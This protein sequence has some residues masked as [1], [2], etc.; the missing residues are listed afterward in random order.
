M[1]SLANRCFKIMLPLFF[2]IS[3]L[4]FTYF[5]LRISLVMPIVLPLLHCQSR[6]INDWECF[7][8]ASDTIR[9]CCFSKSTFF[10]FCP[11]TKKLWLFF[12]LSCK[13]Q[14]FMEVPCNMNPLE[15]LPFWQFC[16]LVLAKCIGRPGSRE[17]LPN[18]SWNI[19]YGEIYE[20][21]LL[22]VL[23]CFFPPN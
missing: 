15:T 22:F 11:I 18:S 1:K 13:S 16:V 19:S 5:S 8:Y 17:Y 23:F 2:F 21:C 3:F 7:F 14:K 10:F 9:V 6:M 12:N 20:L 4:G